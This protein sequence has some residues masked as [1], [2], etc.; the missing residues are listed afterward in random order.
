[1]FLNKAG[2]NT[3]NVDVTA[4]C[5]EVRNK[6]ERRGKRKQ[7]KKQEKRGNAKLDTSS[8]P[9]GCS[10]VSLPIQDPAGKL[11]QPDT[12]RPRFEDL[13]KQRK[14]KGHPTPHKI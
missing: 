10:D 6:L 1:V 11:Q 9:G 7:T 13:S 4:Q 5:V 2:R 3:N 12:T 14:Q 8:K